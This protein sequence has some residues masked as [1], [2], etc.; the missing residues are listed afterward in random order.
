MRQDIKGRVEQIRQGKVPEGLC[1]PIK[2]KSWELYLKNGMRP[3]FLLF[4]PVPVI[5][6]TI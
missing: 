2:K 1:H 5:I 4:L 6:Q 3:H